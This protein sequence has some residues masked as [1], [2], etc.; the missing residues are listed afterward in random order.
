ML[1]RRH[2]KR[3]TTA[4]R[5]KRSGGTTPTIGGSVFMDPMAGHGSGNIELHIRRTGQVP[6]TLICIP[7]NLV[8]GAHSSPYQVVSVP[9]DQR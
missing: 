1:P 9:E 5:K 6:Y 8:P 3:N 7:R 2:G 4:R